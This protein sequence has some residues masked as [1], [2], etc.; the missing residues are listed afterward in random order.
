LLRYRYLPLCFQKLRSLQFLHSPDTSRWL[1][2][3]TL[4]TA[5][6]LRA[7]TQEV[8]ANH[9]Q[10]KAHHAMSLSLTK[11]NKDFFKHT[12]GV[13]LLNQL[14]EDSVKWTSIDH[15]TRYNAQNFFAETT[16]SL[17][18]QRL[19]NPAI[20]SVRLNNR[21]HA[22][23]YYDASEEKLCND[24]I[25]KWTDTFST[26]NL[27]FTRI[28]SVF[29][30]LEFVNKQAIV[31]E[32][33]NALVVCFDDRTRVFSDQTMRDFLFKVS[34]S[35]IDTDTWERAY[36]NTTFE[37]RKV[38]VD[39]LRTKLSGYMGSGDKVLMFFNLKLNRLQ[40]A[41]PSFFV[42]DNG[43]QFAIS[44]KVTTSD[45]TYILGSSKFKTFDSLLPNYQDPG[46][47]LFL[48]SLRDIG[49][50]EE[51]ILAYLFKTLGKSRCYLI[52]QTGIIS[53]KDLV[54]LLKT[55]SLDNVGRPC[56]FV[57]DPECPPH[58]DAVTGKQVL[59][60]TYTVPGPAHCI[61]H[62]A[63]G[64]MSIEYLIGDMTKHLSENSFHE[65]S[66]LLVG[67]DFGP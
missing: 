41:D 9:H 1:K 10:L 22:L 16:Q 55:V 6:S 5:Q 49:F 47:Y 33:A 2:T 14:L 61:V 21:Q 36:R 17:A 60:G 48:K 43:E 29:L 42:L 4:F 12:S 63:Y 59:L 67:G 51:V 28:R 39:Q 18:E 31:L 45:G 34:G 66:R 57:V 64:L 44:F 56:F 50:A 11:M 65:T 15:L 30:S 19:F 35:L 24:A 25:A 13:G 3:R 52:L 7:V 37:G 53:V 38:L 27:D 32:T 20:V 26:P 8:V 46:K 23:Q 58:I 40:S 54:L 62:L